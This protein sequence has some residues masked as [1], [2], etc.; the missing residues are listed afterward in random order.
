MFSLVLV[1]VRVCFVCFRECFA[2]FRLEKPNGYPQSS[3]GGGVG[4]KAFQGA[5]KSFVGFRVFS[6]GV[7]LVLM[8]FRLCFLCFRFFFR[9]CFVV[10]QAFR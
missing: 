2:G 5:R 3:G 1:G 6:L 7:S 9:C 4:V 8:C 10:F